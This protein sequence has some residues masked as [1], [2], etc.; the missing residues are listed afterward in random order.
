MQPGS[1]SSPVFSMRQSCFSGKCPRPSTEDGATIEL[2]SLM[3]SETFSAGL[4]WRNGHCKG[5]E[6]TRLPKLLQF[7]NCSVKKILK[8]TKNNRMSSFYFSRATVPKIMMQFKLMMSRCRII[9]AK[10]SLII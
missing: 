2:S 10:T 7:L 3:N 4:T 5:Q 1:T 8:C 6:F 9:T